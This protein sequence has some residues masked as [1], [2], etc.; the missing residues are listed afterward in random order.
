[1]YRTETTI[2]LIGGISSSG[3]TTT[4][5]ALQKALAKENRP[6]VHV[7][8][9]EFVGLLPPEWFN[10][11]VSKKIP[12]N[13]DGIVLKRVDDDKGPKV[14]LELGPVGMNLVMAY[15]PVVATIAS[16][17]S[18]IIIDGVFS[19][20]YLQEAAKHFGDFRVYCIGIRCPLEVVVERERSRGAIGSII[21]LAR[22]YT[23]TSDAHIHTHYDLLVDTHTLT[24]E[25]AA[26][27][28]IEFMATQDEPQALNKLSNQQQ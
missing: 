13:P 12:Q 3:K 21:G 26:Q 9:D 19:T 2:I 18:N 20:G 4:A 28:I 5:K 25:Q 1:M 14:V 11:D 6:F 24:P 10:P 23:E 16:Y 17:G 27:K 22:G 7:P 15:M 8:I